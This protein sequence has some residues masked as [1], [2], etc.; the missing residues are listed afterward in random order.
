MDSTACGSYN[1]SIGTL[2][3]T[4]LPAIPPPYDIYITELVAGLRAHQELC[5]IRRHVLEAHR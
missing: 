1:A 2:S 5:G 3:G 4:L